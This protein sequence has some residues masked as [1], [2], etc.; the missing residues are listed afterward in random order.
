MEATNAFFFGHHHD[1]VV[2]MMTKKFQDLLDYDKMK[3]RKILHVDWIAGNPSDPIK[4]VGGNA[5]HGGMS[6]EDR[7]LSESVAR[8]VMRITYNVP[9]WDETM[10]WNKAMFLGDWLSDH[11]GFRQFFVE[12]QVKRISGFDDTLLENCGIS[13]EYV[14]LSLHD[15]KAP[16]VTPIVVPP[17][18]GQELRSQAPHRELP[19]P[20]ETSC[21]PVPEVEEEEYAAP[22]PTAAPTPA[23]TP[24]MEVLTRSADKG[25]GKAAA[26][27]DQVATLN[28]AA[29]VF[30]SSASAQ[31]P[32]K[33]TPLPNIGNLALG[34]QA[35]T[36]RIPSVETT[37]PRTCTPRSQP[38]PSPGS[39]D[40][41]EYEEPDDRVISPTPTGSSYE[42]E[43]SIYLADNVDPFAALIPAH[44][45]PAISAAD[46]HR[47][48]QEFDRSAHAKHEELKKIFHFLQDPAFM[49]RKS[50]SFI[51]TVRMVAI[52]DRGN[53]VNDF[54]GPR[55]DDRYG[56]L[57][58]QGGW[59][60]PPFEERIKWRDEHKRSYR[61]TSA[62]LGK[63]E[64][65]LRPQ[66]QHVMPLRLDWSGG[67]EPR[68]FGPAAPVWRELCDPCLEDIYWMVWQ[69]VSGRQ[70]LGFNPGNG[71]GVARRD[72]A[73]DESLLKQCPFKSPSAEALYHAASYPRG[74]EH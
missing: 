14:W 57:I 47:H 33:R 44:R 64:G 74:K 61:N 71:F 10:T 68:Y 69:L 3:N 24:S 67:L 5:A 43:G 63:Y 56:T 58:A 46:L 36:N 39:F 37:A 2:A 54:T 72:P 22:A 20:A 42:D 55:I 18:V 9:Q 31:S 38:L 41:M 29:Q 66:V 30:T 52:P 53:V 8:S 65:L 6:A 15:D 73:G 7:R 49:E 26:P 40:S 23:P 28:P 11:K 35:G 21:E 59:V 62:K 1:Q 19:T 70:F 34:Q 32:Q 13:P 4:K 45:T 27:Q 50:K 25:K 17:V 16:A 51:Y 60:V 48:R 12:I